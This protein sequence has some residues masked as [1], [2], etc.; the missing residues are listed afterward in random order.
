MGTIVNCIKF[1]IGVAFVFF[2]LT[3]GVSLNMEIGFISIDSAIVSNSFLFAVFS[4]IFVSTL[5]VLIGELYKYH[6]TKE[7]IENSLYMQ[8]AFL[9]GQLLIIRNNIGR[10]LQEPTEQLPQNMLQFSVSNSTFFLNNLKGLEYCTFNGK[11]LIELTLQS[12]I[13]DGVLRLEG[14]LIDCSVLDIAINEDRIE[15]L[16]RGIPN[17]VITSASKKSH[18]VLIILNKQVEGYINEIDSVLIDIDKACNNRFTWIKRR[19]A[20]SQYISYSKFSGV[21]EFIS[22]YRM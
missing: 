18:E 6:D 12:F 2:L 1:L 20:T 7:R 5:V 19:N 14:F 16:Q 21:D 13:G 3:Y 22:K 4:G 17:P 11:S 10:M 8:F 9:Y 15:C